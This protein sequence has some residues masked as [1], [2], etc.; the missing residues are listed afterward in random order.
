LML[1]CDCDLCLVVCFISSTHISKK[2]AGESV[3][4]A[5]SLISP[6]LGNLG[7]SSPRF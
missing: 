5:T 4:S 2:N 3:V 1:Q 7:Y 6:Y